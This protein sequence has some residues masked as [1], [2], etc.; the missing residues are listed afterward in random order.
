MATACLGAG[1]SANAR[2]LWVGGYT[3]TRA[4]NPGR[5]Q[6][7]TTSCAGGEVRWRAGRGGGAEAHRGRHS[8]VE[9]QASLVG[10]DGAAELHAHAAVDLDVARVIQPGDAEHD[11][12]L[13]LA[14]LAEH[15][16][17]LGALLE[18]GLQ[19]G[20]HLDHGV[21]ELLLVG[22]AAAHALQH[23]LQRRR[24]RGW[25]GLAPLARPPRQE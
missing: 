4:Q 5:S 12:P 7:H 1:A 2:P 22:V 23:G 13:G 19:R 24:Q 17:Q 15:A 25:R 16:Q 11:E 20:G 21:E 18:H 6:H 9:A 3:Q 10:A 14:D 8:G